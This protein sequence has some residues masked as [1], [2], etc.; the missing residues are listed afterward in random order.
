MARITFKKEKEEIDFL[1]DGKKISPVYVV[2]GGIEYA[3]KLNFREKVEFEADPIFSW[4]DNLGFEVRF[5]DSKPPLGV[6]P[7]YIA[8]EKRITELTDG[9]KRQLKAEKPNYSLINRWAE[10]I[11][12]QSDI[13][14]F[15]RSYDEN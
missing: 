12:N 10:E 13:I 5:K 2:E 8:A 14:K 1:V 4:K 9:I 6:M 15:D 7:C 11:K 3:A